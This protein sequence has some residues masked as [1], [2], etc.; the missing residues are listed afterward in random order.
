VALK[1]FTTDQREFYVNE[2]FIYQ[3][4]GDTVGKNILKYHGKLKEHSNYALDLD[5]LM[6]A[7]LSKI[8]IFS[9][10]FQDGKNSPRSTRPI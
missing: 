8:P 6:M 3:G 5:R 2:R 1:V 7:E 9:F 10:S 4:M